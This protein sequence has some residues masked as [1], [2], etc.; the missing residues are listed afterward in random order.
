[1][2]LICLKCKNIISSQVAKRKYVVDFTVY[3]LWK[4]VCKY[5]DFC[6]IFARVRAVSVLTYRPPQWVC[7]LFPRLGVD[8]S[9]GYS[10]DTNFE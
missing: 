10:V 1:M 7:Y 5:A 6:H 2:I 8:W 9:G 3:R 4:F